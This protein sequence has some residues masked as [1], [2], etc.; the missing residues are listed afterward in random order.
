MNENQ[1][2]NKIFEM[3]ND[4]IKEAKRIFNVEFPD[5]T[6]DLGMKGRN[7]GQACYKRSIGGVYEVKLRFNLDLARENFNEF[8][9]VITHEICHL[10]VA[11]T[12]K[13][14]VSPHG[15]EWALA[16]ELMGSDPKRCHS[17]KLSEE[18][19]IDNRPFVYVCRCQD[20]TKRHY[21]SNNIHRKVMSG[22]TRVCKTCKS[23]IKFLY[24]MR[25]ESCPK[26]GVKPIEE[27]AVICPKVVTCPEIK[28]S[29]NTFDV[30]DICKM[31]GLDPKKVRRTLRKEENSLPTRI[32][33]SWTFNVVDKEKVLSV[34]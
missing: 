16:M 20:G 15:D 8:K 29:G 28:I 30:K 34:F 32:G 10:V 33:N 5:L 13:Y 31:T 19:L 2:M 4:G 3:T 1:L 12:H 23:A 6:I 27:E 7:A 18:F 14:E 26:L 24:D 22:R 11:L 9:S 17:L 25:H 21:L